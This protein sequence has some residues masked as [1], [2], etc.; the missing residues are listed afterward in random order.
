M[1]F[2]RRPLIE[3]NLSAP[4]TVMD[5]IKGTKI[6]RRPPRPE[7]RD[8]TTLS[9]GAGNCTRPAVGGNRTRS[10]RRADKSFSQQ[11]AHP[12]S[13]FLLSFPIS[14]SSIYTICHDYDVV[15][16]RARGKGVPLFL[17][18]LGIDRPYRTSN[19]GPSSATSLGRRRRKS[20]GNRFLGHKMD[21]PLS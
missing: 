1:P 15:V 6:R 13:S 8:E 9:S 12:Y 20:R 18:G 21:A 11:S 19:G 14:S 2:S 7:R 17:R 16:R 10:S 4:S 3:R 5:S